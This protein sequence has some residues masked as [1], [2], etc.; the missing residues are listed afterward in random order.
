[1]EP[2]ELYFL[3]IVITHRST[4]NVLILPALITNSQSDK[5]QIFAAKQERTATGNN[6]GTRQ[7][8]KRDLQKDIMIQ[9][10]S[11]NSRVFPILSKYEFS[12]FQVHAVKYFRNILYKVIIVILRI[13]TTLRNMPTY[14]EK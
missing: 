8:V 14:F 5:T 3:F 12:V 1:M 13:S 4:T 10:Q 7:L 9:K 6:K 11:F 2:K